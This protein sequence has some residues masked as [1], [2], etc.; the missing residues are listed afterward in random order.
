MMRPTALAALCAT[1]LLASP[2]RAVAQNLF[3]V[4]VFPDETLEPG[5]TSVEFHNVLM[6]SGTRLPD[7]MLDPSSHLHLSFE[8][9]HGWTTA[10]ETGFFVETSPS[11]DDRHAALTGFHMR[12]KYRF[13]PWPRFPFHVSVSAEYAFVK[14]PG[15]ETFR[16]ALAITPI[17]ERHIRG[18]E[19]SFNPGIEVGLRGPEAGSSPVF[20]PSAKLASKA[21]GSVWFGVEYY[22]ETGS[23]KHFEPLSEQHHLVFPVIDFRTPSGWDLNVGVG[24]GLTGSSEHWV[25]KWIVGLRLPQ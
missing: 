15:D 17:F 22:A 6:P 19:M 16:Q 21:S 11:A 13:S 4:Q 9:S 18:F 8:V 10:F 12:P 20:E 14:Q 23:I 25:V 7:R 1:L 5:E 3:E 24:R 2:G